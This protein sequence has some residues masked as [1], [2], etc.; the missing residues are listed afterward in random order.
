VF[1]EVI[2]KDSIAVAEQEARE[3]RKGKC[4]PQLLC[5]PVSTKNSGLTELVE[6]RQPSL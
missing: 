5:G 6:F 2:A 3:S 1:L 4:F